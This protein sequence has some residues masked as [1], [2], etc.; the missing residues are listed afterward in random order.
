MTLTALVFGLLL[1][2]LCP[3][4]CMYGGSTVPGGGGMGGLGGASLGDRPPGGGRGPSSRGGGGGHRVVHPVSSAEGQV[5][6][7]GVL[8]QWSG[9]TVLYTRCPAL[10]GGWEA[11]GMA[12]TA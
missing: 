7:R 3:T 1:H 10:R 5:G 12:G 4:V 6:G 2:F 11:P 8:H 9:G